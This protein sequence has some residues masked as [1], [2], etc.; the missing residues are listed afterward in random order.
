MIQKYSSRNYS[1]KISGLIS[2]FWPLKNLSWLEI[3]SKFEPGLSDYIR[4]SKTF[5]HMKELE[6]NL[7]K[8]KGI[9]PMAVKDVI[10]V[11]FNL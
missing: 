1:K 2:N 9:T 11:T 7:P 8:F 3:S 6:K 10:Q 5:W 4:D